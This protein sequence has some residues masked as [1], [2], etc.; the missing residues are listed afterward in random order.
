MRKQVKTLKTHSHLEKKF[1]SLFS[2]ELLYCLIILSVKEQISFNKDF[3][4]CDLLKLI[5]RT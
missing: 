3:A 1:L 5:E 4:A 2:V